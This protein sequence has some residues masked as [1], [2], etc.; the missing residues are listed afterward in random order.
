MLLLEENVYFS[1]FE[2]GIAQVEIYDQP[3]PG[4]VQIAI[5]PVLASVGRQHWVSTGS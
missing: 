1:N 5:V 3:S 2:R 4:P